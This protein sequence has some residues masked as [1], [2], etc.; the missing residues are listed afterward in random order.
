MKIG[1][2]GGPGSFNHTAVLEY[3]EK[4]RLDAEIV[5][6]FTSEKVLSA[7]EGGS[8]DLGFFAIFNTLGGI[9]EESIKA[10]GNHKYQYLSTVKLKIRHF[11]MTLP[12]VAIEECN[13]VIAHP[14]VLIQCAKSMSERYPTLSQI[15]GEGD[16]IDT[17]TAAKALVEGEID[18]KRAILGNRLIADIYGLRVVDEDLQDSDENVTHFLVVK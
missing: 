1:I 18:R 15:S 2:Q 10:I 12:D 11:L 4:N 13:T 5:Y 9:V 14:Q 17:A 8:V 3:V 7:V 16:L 6:L